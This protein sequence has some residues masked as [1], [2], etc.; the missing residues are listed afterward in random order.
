MQV[1]SSISSCK[2]P[3][4]FLEPKRT[5][6]P[7]SCSDKLEFGFEHVPARSSIPRHKHEHREEIIFIH[8][9]RLIAWVDGHG[10][11]RECVEGEAIH[12]PL[13]TEHYFRN[14]T[15]ELV[16]LTYTLS[17]SAEAPQDNSL[18]K[19]MS[20]PLASQPSVKV[21]ILVC[22]TPM[23]EIVEHHGNYAQLFDALLKKVADKAPVTTVAF[24]VVSGQYPFRPEEF[25]GFLIT[26]SK[27]TAYHTDPWILS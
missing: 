3:H 18:V 23:D 15:D 8:E 7:V 22:D 6:Y 21:G 26:G 13:D 14:D 1:F 17:V 11:E 4:E 10:G 9:G 2:V 5:L 24:D 12:I 25:D 27:Y 16:V 19:Q 20:E